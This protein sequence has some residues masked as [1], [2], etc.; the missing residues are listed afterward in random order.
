MDVCGCINPRPNCP[1]NTM[2]NAN[3]PNATFSQNTTGWI[4]PK[5][6]AVMN[7]SSPSCW[8]CKPKSIAVINVILKSFRRV[9]RNRNEI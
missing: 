5:C 9:K 7:P 3:W 2:Y 4:C 8:Y 6:S 1:C